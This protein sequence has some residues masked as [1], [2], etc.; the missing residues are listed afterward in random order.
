VNGAFSAPFF[1]RGANPTAGGHQ[2]LQGFVLTIAAGF[3][4]LKLFPNS[5]KS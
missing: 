4:Q 5:G 2:T 3:L 1:W